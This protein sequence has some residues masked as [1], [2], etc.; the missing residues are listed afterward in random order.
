MSKD[1]T[2]P[3]PEF[4]AMMDNAGG[5]WYLGK[6]TPRENQIDLALK[7]HDSKKDDPTQVWTFQNISEF[8]DANTTALAEQI[9]DTKI[10]KQELADELKNLQT[11]IRKPWT[12]HLNTTR[13]ET[14]PFPKPQTFFDKDTFVPERLANALMQFCKFATVHDTKEIYIYNPQSGIWETQGENIIHEA[15]VYV[16]KEQEKKSRR[17]EV[18][19]IIQGKTI[20]NRQDFRLF[21]MDLIPLSNGV[22]SRAT[23]QLRPH[24]PD[25]KF[26][27]TFPFAYDRGATCPRFDEFLRKV[28]VTDEAIDTI[29][30]HIALL[31]YLSFA[32]HRILVLVGSGRNG[33]TTLILIIENLI[34]ERNTTHRSINQLSESRFALADLY[35]K[36]LNSYADMPSRP[37]FNTEFFKQLSGGDEITGEKKFKGSFNFKSFA[38]WW[39]ACNQLPRVEY[40]DSDAYHSRLDIIDFPNRFLPPVTDTNTNTPPPSCPDTDKPKTEQNDKSQTYM[41]KNQTELVAE[42]TTPDELAG[43]FNHAMTVLDELLKRGHFKHEKSIEEKRERYIELSDPVVCFAEDMLDIT[44][45]DADWI[46][47][48]LLYKRFQEYLQEN[49]RNRMSDKALNKRL[50]D[51]YPV[52]AERK[53]KFLGKRHIVWS[54]VKWSDPPVECFVEDRLEITREDTDR[55]ERAEAYKEFQKYHQKNYH[56]RCMSEEAF[57]KCLRKVCSALV[58]TDASNTAW[59]GIKWKKEEDAKED[60]KDTPDPNTLDP[61]I[62]G[63]EKNGSF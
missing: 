20:T 63:E 27:T 40:D 51:V 30:E 57:D 35:G 52:M 23:K 45:E 28:V 18:E 2:E 22:Y 55:I 53:L 50:R 21:T 12:I 36:V 31:F 59:Y 19:D 14:E 8:L 4:K 6:L 56:C 24:D 46:D 43:I 61:H 48:H 10:D 62:Q 7:R 33:K 41:A 9:K 44:Q 25:D 37:I 49:H 47:R 58:S 26:I 16:L 1:E 29:W 42:C 5:E 32:F 15:V 11:A 60:A 39:L 17:L 34:G 3:S 13:H 54:G 38:K